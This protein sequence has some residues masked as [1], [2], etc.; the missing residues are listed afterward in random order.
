MTFAG[1]LAEVAVALRR[2]GPAALRQ[3]RLQVGRPLTPM[4]AQSAP[5]VGDALERTGPAAVEWKLDGVRIQVHRDG[6][7]VA[8]FTR[9]LDEVGA[10]MPEV[11]AGGPL[12]ARAQ[13]WC[14]TA[15]RSRCARTVGPGR[16]RSPPPVP[17]DTGRPAPASRCD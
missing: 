11:V 7:D 8:V 1:G 12:P 16:S 4:L 6:D 2:D 5:D 17:R 14:W 10:R 3:F 9:T 15:R 13:R